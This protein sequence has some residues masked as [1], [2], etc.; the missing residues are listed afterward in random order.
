MDAYTA[1]PLPSNEP[2]LGYAP[3]SAE[4]AELVSQ[5]ESMSADGPVEILG[6]YGPTRRPGSGGGRYQ[7]TMPSDHSHVL[8]HVQQSSAADVTLSIGAAL[9]AGREWRASLRRTRSRVPESRRP[10]RWTLAGQDQRCDDARPGEDR[11]TGGDRRG[12]R[13]DR[14]PSVQRCVRVTDHVQPAEQPLRAVEPD[15]LQA[16]RRVRVCNH[17]VQLHRD[18]RQPSDLGGSDG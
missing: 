2:V 12:V 9:E 4:R 16:T 15:G 17:A 14:L 7:I 10:H 5:L 18:R 11:A 6:T 1:V 13:T 8:G 3:G